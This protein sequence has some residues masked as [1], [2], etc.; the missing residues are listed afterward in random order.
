MSATTAS[1]KPAN[2]LTKDNFTPAANQVGNTN[3]EESR[4]PNPL[5]DYASYNYNFSL[6]ILTD[7]EFNN[8]SYRSGTSG[9]WLAR[10][11]SIT[12][13]DRVEAFAGKF[14]YFI[15]DV[16][17]KHLTGFDQTTGNTNAIG[18]SFKIVEPYSMGLF[19]QAIQ[20]DALRKGHQNYL[21]APMLLMLEFKGHKDIFNQFENIS[22]TTKYFPLKLRLIEMK[23][24]QQGSVYD[25]NA[26]PVN[27]YAFEQAK[28]TFTT[29]VSVVGKT[30][31]DMLKDHPEKSLEVYLN[32]RYKDQ[33]K[34]KHVNQQD[35]YEI[36][37]PD[38][39]LVSNTI[40]DA[41]LGFS[42]YEKGIVPFSK[43][44]LT[45]EN[46]VFKR[47]NLT[48]NPKQAEFKFAQ[49]TDIVNAINQVVLMSEY[50]KKA[51]STVSS[52][53]FIKWWR[54]EVE[55][56]YISSN[57]NMDK[58]GTKPKKFIYRVVPYMVDSSFFLPPNERRK[59]TEADKQQVAK[60][61]NYI[62]SGKNIDVL[63]FDINFKTGF[64]TTLHADV[65]QRNAAELLARQ[66][67]TGEPQND[68][69]NWG[70]LT[71]Q[72][73]GEP[74]VGKKESATRSELIKTKT[75]S[76]NQ[77]G[78][79]KDTA[80]VLAAKQFQDAITAGVDMITV[81]LTILG[82][83]YYIG[84]S[85]MGNYHAGAKSKYV[86]SDDS[87]TWDATEIHII[88]NFRTPADIDLNTG[89]YDFNKLYDA[90]QFSGLYRVLTGESFFVRGKFTQKLRIIRLK[91]QE[92]PS[93]SGDLAQKGA[94]DPY[95]D[96]VRQAD[97]TA[98]GAG[99]GSSVF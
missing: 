68:R 18:F 41:D 56:Q 43:D 79:G 61:Y 88:L 9:P 50:G 65:N 39:P 59:G 30:V 42:L 16:S 91:N 29:S 34:N 25:I 62:Y 33:E 26:Y 17:I 67:S 94:Y 45:Y 52:D 72:V 28:V 38:T 44:N 83:P 1:A 23:V 12:P 95:D 3:T 15:E 8:A 85:G 64:Y 75:R 4:L 99:G 24:T 82:D 11:A 40:K 55:L 71:Q 89:M 21:D 27:E 14:E 63:D 84:D 76:S 49:D 90:K 69:Q 81:D 73:E 51:L 36:Q 47:G 87:M 86:N 96:L 10:S 20:T 80:A 19:F 92:S 60:I 32:N 2:V 78:S 77:G 54:V 6:K 35:V 13:E 98:I 93:G 57:A 48:I 37:F 7:A 97:A 58:T 70:A 5:H 74:T 22:N 31:K 66:M 46:G 53:G